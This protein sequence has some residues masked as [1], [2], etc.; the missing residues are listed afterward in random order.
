MEIVREQG[1][2]FL[3]ATL[4]IVSAQEF[5]IFRVPGKCACTGTHNFS[6]APEN[7]S[8]MGTH[9][10][11]FDPKIVRADGRRILRTSL[12]IV[13]GQGSRILCASL[14]IGCRG[15]QLLVSLKNMRALGRYFD[16]R[17]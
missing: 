1:R 15:T 9:H 14:E 2:T 8:C 7:F 10:F 6:C 17:P 16:V 11:P 5:P 13:H 4:E 12:E 3:G